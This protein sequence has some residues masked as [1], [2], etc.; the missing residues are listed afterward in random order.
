MDTIHF[1]TREKVVE[2]IK[3]VQIK[4]KG[5]QKGAEASYENIREG[6]RGRNV[7]RVP[8]VK[9]GRRHG[10]MRKVRAATDQRAWPTHEGVQSLLEEYT[11]FKTQMGMKAE[12]L[13]ATH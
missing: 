13:K 11:P 1:S 9:M 4:V 7:C 3:E 8:R 6:F 5:T 12:W 2:S 10:K